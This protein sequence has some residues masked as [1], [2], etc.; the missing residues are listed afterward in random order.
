MRRVLSATRLARAGATPRPVQATGARQEVVEVA[1][2]KRAAS[3]AT[4]S[5]LFGVCEFDLLERQRECF[6]YPVD[7]R[8]ISRR[9]L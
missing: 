8:W 5:S 7:F 6:R 3:G 1:T 9:R 4:T 2:L